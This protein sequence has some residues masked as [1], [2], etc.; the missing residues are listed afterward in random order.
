MA[1]FPDLARRWAREDEVVHAI[2]FAKGRRPEE[3][4]TVAY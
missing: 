4:G 3:G 1:G 2:E